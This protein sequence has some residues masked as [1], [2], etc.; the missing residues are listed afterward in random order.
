MR[1]IIEEVFNSHQEAFT[2]VKEKSS[3]IEEIAGVLIDA[4]Q[5]QHKILFCG[6]GGSAAD[7][8]H[9]AAEF[10]GRFKKDDIVL[11]A[12][13]LSVNTSML[14]A[15]ANDFG[16]EKVFSQQVK[17]LGSPGDV[18]V[19]IST[20]GNSANVACAVRQAHSQGLKT[21][22]FLGNEGGTLK[23]LVDIPLLV[24]ANDTARI[25]EMHILIGHI[26]CELVDQF[27]SGGK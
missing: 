10:V 25:Q 24:K 16:F 4:L 7:S 14:T 13:A 15:I 5:G 1:K 26:L 8:Q 18:L 12:L 27:F 19:A 17:A 9:L 2:Y 22:G 3:L 21:I 6:N 20:S 23:D 11:P